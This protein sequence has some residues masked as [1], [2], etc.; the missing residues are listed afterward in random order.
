[1]LVLIAATI[2][3]NGCNSKSNSAKDPTKQNITIGRVELI[4]YKVEAGSPD[5]K[6][7]RKGKKSSEYLNMKKTFIESFEI[8]K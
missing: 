2:L 3:L 5:E 1:M 7:I 8:R 6:L 4:E